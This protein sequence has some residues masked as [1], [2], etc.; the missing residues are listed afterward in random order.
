MPAFLPEYV[1]QDIL[2]AYKYP[3][4]LH[5]NSEWIQWVY[6]L[7]QPDRRYALEFIESWSS[8]RIL[9]AVS[10]LL[11]SSTALGI[12]WAVVK[13]DA[14]TAFT[15]ASFFLGA[16]SRTRATHLRIIRIANTKW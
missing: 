11:A 16:G 5:S 14:Q 8:L 3:E 13:D 4:K 10:V 7:R 9:I 1:K 6:N 2:F 15:V 12:T